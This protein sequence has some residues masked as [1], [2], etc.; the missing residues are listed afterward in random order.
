M[1]IHCQSI[2]LLLPVNL[3]CN[4]ILSRFGHA[5]VLLI[6]YK[7]YNIIIVFQFSNGYCKECLEEQRLMPYY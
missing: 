5:I 2:L 7:T 4:L 3:G 6:V 1:L